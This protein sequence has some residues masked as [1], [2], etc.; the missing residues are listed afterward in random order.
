MR[1]RKYCCVAYKI[2]HFITTR[3]IN[4]HRMEDGRM[5]RRMVEE[6]EKNKV[7]SQAND[8]EENLARDLYFHTKWRIHTMC[9]SVIITNP[10]SHA[11]Y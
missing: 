3:L 7:S 2:R 11:S 9:S 10:I 1:K 4:E 6:N 8:L 5:D